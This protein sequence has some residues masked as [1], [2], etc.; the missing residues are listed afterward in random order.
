M[1]SAVIIILL[2]TALGCTQKTYRVEEVANPV[3]RE[4]TLFVSFEDLT[5]PKF[6]ALKSKYQLD[7]VLKNEQDEF[8]R[9]LLLRDWI[10][11]VISIQDFGDPYPGAGY[12]EAILDAA[13]K[14]QGFHCGHFMV[15]QNAVMNA[16]GYVT[17]CIGSGPGVKGGP[18]GH[19]G[20]DEIWLNKYQK[21]FLSDAKYNHHFEKN[22]IPLS[23]LE[24][25]DEYLK[26]K[27]ADIILVKGADRTPIETDSVADKRGVYIPTSKAQFA[28]WYA[29]LEWNETGNIYSA[30]P[31]FDSKLV[32]YRDDYFTK[33]TWIWD[34]KPHWAYQTDHVKYTDSREAIEWTPNII[35]G[36]VSVQDHTA[37][38]TLHSITPNFKE[39]QMK[40]PPSGA[41]VKCDSVVNI[42]LDGD[43]VEAS[44][45]S[46][47]LAG[48][49]GPE[50]K[51]LLVSQ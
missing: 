31:D 33:N 4:N 48:V 44:F 29:W 20:I 37:R 5:S 1:K 51:V 46:V 47:N 24:I 16:Y 50:Y 14:G 35:Q 13:L 39:Y 36:N 2:L 30:W 34:G 19:H 23:A 42:P 3:F 49:Y 26:N 9:I 17:R 45:R 18:D 25:R 28:Q 6:S 43:R 8:K 12:P 15:V 41:W 7:T 27:A 11:G 10:R 32:M 22:G 38:I 21:W 40:A